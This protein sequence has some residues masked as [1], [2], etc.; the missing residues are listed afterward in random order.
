MEQDTDRQ[1]TLP[2]LMA[3]GLLRRYESGSETA[4]MNPE[5]S[6]VVSS[7]QTQQAELSMVQQA[8]ASNRRLLCVEYWR[9]ED[10]AGAVLIGV[11]RESSLM[12]LTAASAFKH[13]KVACEQNTKQKYLSLF[14]FLL[15]THTGRWHSNT[16]RNVVE[17]TAVDLE[18][19]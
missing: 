14:L 9:T 1:L 12:I 3:G 17:Q 13:H 7:L 10:L 16:D 8:M 18:G 4:Y 2:C 11:S 6:H 19:T 15:K 5:Y